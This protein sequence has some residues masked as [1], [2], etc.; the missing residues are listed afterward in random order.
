ML[1]L[2]LKSLRKAKKLS[3]EELAKRVSTTKGTISN[4]ENGYSSPSN[5]MLLKLSRELNTTTDY[6]LGRTDNPSELKDYDANEINE[7]YDPEDP[8][9]Q[10]AVEI[11]K[12]LQQGK[13]PA[14]AGL[15]ILTILN[16]PEE[17][18]KQFIKSLKRIIESLEQD[19]EKRSDR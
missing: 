14:I 2:R 12:E 11:Y 17:E 5:E 1:R 9:W 10:K 19:F 8:Y 4:Y 6:L 16:L 3:Q 13:K 18:R 15:D 7:L